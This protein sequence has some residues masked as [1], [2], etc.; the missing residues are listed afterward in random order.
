[1]RNRRRIVGI[2]ISLTLYTLVVMVLVFYHSARSGQ[3]YAKDFYP[4]HEEN[5]PGASYPIEGTDIYVTEYHK[6]HVDDKWNVS[7]RDCSSWLF[8]RTG[9]VSVDRD[10]YNRVK[11]GQTVHFGPEK[12]WTILNAMGSIMTSLVML[13][14]AGWVINRLI[15]Q[16]ITEPGWSNKGTFLIPLGGILFFSAVP[17]AFAMQGIG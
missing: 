15:D 10:T 5:R 1:M 3:V 16:F 8:C 14:L 13:S 2:T 6:E 11:I 17:L 12:G 4:A 7:V 9:D